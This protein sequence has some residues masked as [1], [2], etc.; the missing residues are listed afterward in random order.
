MT[1]FNSDRIRIELKRKTNE[2]THFAYSFI[3]IEQYIIK[4]IQMFTHIVCT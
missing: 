1:F 2:K 3:A 4:E